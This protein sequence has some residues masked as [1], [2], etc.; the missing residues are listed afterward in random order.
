MIK[1]T[2]RKVL[3][4]MIG[5]GKR[6]AI[7][8]GVIDAL[9]VIFSALLAL[10]LRFNFETIPAQYLEPAIRCLPLDVV[11]AI[12]VM[13]FFKLYNRVWTYASIEESMSII[14]ATVCI[15]TELD[16]YNNFLQIPIPRSLYVFD[17]ALLTLLRPSFWKT[18]SKAIISW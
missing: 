14:K 15:E 7:F 6:R 10:A 16:L 12:F 18:D 17:A 4:Y 13:R 8:I 3:Y 11:I 2:S 5:S 1:Y 9:I